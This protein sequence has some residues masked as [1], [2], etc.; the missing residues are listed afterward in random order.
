MS[1][2]G[3][4]WEVLLLG[5]QRELVCV[6]DSTA[7]LPGGIAYPAHALERRTSKS[8]CEGCRGIHLCLL[9][10]SGRELSCSSSLSCLAEA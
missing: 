10:M 7:R 2:R 3:V 4:S 8:M 1:G 5:G 9:Q 6:P